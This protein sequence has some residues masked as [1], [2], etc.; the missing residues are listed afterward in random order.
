MSLTF[1]S[2]KERDISS[3]QEIVEGF[4]SFNPAQI[5]AFLS[6]SQNIAIIAKLDGM[7]I[8]LIYGYSLTRM[9]GKAP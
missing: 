7:T 6:E 4:M 3:I 2:L 9:D 8:G 5:K 1:E